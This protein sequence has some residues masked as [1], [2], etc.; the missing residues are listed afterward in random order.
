MPWALLQLLLD[1]LV[2]PPE[3][4]L[5]LEPLAF[6]SALADFSAGQLLEMKM[7]LLEKLT[8]EVWQPK[9]LEHSLADALLPLF[10]CLAPIAALLLVW[11]RSS[12]SLP[13]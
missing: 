2:E 5:K 4:E 3:V 9:S 7:N 13:R 11:L 12:K 1:W 10:C 6:L 8:V